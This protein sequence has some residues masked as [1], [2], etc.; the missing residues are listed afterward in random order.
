MM[1]LPL[2]DAPSTP[3]TLASADR[4][5]TA[6]RLLATFYL[7]TVLSS[8]LPAANIPALCFCYGLRSRFS[9]DGGCNASPS[10]P[11]TAAPPAVFSSP[12]LPL[13]SCS[14]SFGFRTRRTR[15]CA[16]DSF[17]DAAAHI[18]RIVG[19]DEPLY[20]FGLPPDP[21]TLLFYLDRNAPSLTGKLGDSPP[22]Y[23]I[24]PATKWN[25][26][27]D[28]ALTLEPVYT[29]TSGAY[30]LMLLHPGKTYATIR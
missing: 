25:E 23:V 12:P 2:M 15:A 21:V 26:L 24:I 5:A 14:I 16:R 28:E 13:L 1:V 20:L 29:S 19:R 17:Q 3:V 30:P 11:L 27:K 4:A 8:R 9:S 7:V 10:I 18:N 22:G 6:A